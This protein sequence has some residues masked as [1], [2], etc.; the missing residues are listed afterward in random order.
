M[1]QAALGKPEG[2]RHGLLARRVAIYGPP[3]IIVSQSTG[4]P[5]FR[6]LWSNPRNNVETQIIVINIIAAKNPIFA[7]LTTFAEAYGVRF[8]N[9]VTE[10]VKHVSVWAQVSYPYAKTRRSREWG[11]TTPRN[12]SASTVLS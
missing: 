12:A 4:G 11:M 1:R 10:S 8:P 6:T 2:L 9:G 3:K 7:R 5:G